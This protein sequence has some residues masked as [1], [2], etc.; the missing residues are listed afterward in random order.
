[1]S[2]FF[3]VSI[4]TPIAVALFTTLVVE[5]FAKPQLDARRERILTDRRQIDELIYSFQK[6]AMTLGS[7]LPPPRAGAAE[8]QLMG[9]KRSELVERVGA[10]ADETIVAMSRLSPRYVQ[11][12]SA[13]IGRTTL[14]LAYV[15]GTAATGKHDANYAAVAL[16]PLASALEY[17]DVYFRAN[18]TLQDSQEPWMKRWFWRHNT[19]GDYEAASQKKLEELGLSAE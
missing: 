19:S 1:M 6:L 18:V 8:H 4:A 3:W 14:F 2:E 7:V 16:T 13:H 10:A 12:H 5:Y 11:K 9:V 17:F 15:V